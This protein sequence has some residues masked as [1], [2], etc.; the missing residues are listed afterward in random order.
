MNIRKKGSNLCW[1]TFD[2]VGF[3][4][5]V[6]PKVISEDLMTTYNRDEDGYSI[7]KIPR[8]VNISF[9][10]LRFRLKISYSTKIV[11]INK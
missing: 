6:S 7:F 9:L 10:C 8:V 3:T 1:G 2:F 11:N 5:Q 4:K